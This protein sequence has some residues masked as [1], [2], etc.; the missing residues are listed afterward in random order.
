VIMPE[1]FEPRKERPHFI[2]APDAESLA[3]QMNMIRDQRER[4]LRLATQKGG[5]EKYEEVWDDI[6]GF[7][8]DLRKQLG[9]VCV[10]VAAFHVIGDSGGYETNIVDFANKQYS[11][12]LFLD[13][14]ESDLRSI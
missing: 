13:K 6:T 8:S 14:L 12:R 2:L 9:D 10:S 4:I 5:E 1:T 3:Q 11:I 7:G